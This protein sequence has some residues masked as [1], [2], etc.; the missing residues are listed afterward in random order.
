[1]YWLLVKW[2]KG[3]FAV[4]KQTADLKNKLL[5]VSYFL[6][7]IVSPKV[8]AESSEVPLIEKRMPWDALYSTQFTK[9]NEML[10][11]Y[12]RRTRMRNHCCQVFKMNKKT[13]HLGKWD[14][15]SF[16][17]S[18]PYQNKFS[19]MVIWIKSKYHIINCCRFLK[20]IT[21]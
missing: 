11:K 13:F 14:E 12:S 16:W 2:F 17:F 18:S 15:M 21:C 6:C 9:Y 8:L 20:L 4:H 1:M 19:N 5:N 7:C 10:H 3:M